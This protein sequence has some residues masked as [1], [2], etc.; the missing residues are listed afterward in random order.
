MLRDHAAIG[1]R[2]TIAL[3]AGDATIDWWS[4]DALDAPASLFSL[5]ESKRG[6]AV[7]IKPNEPRGPGE[8]FMHASGAPIVST[9]VHD[10][11]GSVKV[12][13]HLSKGTIVRVLTGRSGRPT[14][15]VQVTP[16]EAFGDPRK[17]KRWSHGVSFGRLVVRGPAVDQPITLG[18]GERAVFTITTSDEGSV[19][20]TAE[21]FVQPSIG[22]AMAEIERYAR[23]WSSELDNVDLEGPFA[24]AARK[25]VRALRL[26]TDRRTG[27]LRR[28]ATTSLPARTGNERNI[29]E[30]YAWL[31]DNASAVVTWERLGRPDLADATRLWLEE[32]AADEFPLAP[33]YR[34]DG[35][36]LPSEEELTL[37]GWQANGP[38]RTGNLVSEA[39]DL[40]AI[41]QASL[42]LDGRRAWPQLERIAAWLAAEGTRADCGRWDS[43]GPKY[44]HVESALAVR[45]ALRALIITAR[46]RDP[47]DLRLIEWEEAARR[48][49]CWLAEEGLFGI[50]ASAGWRRTGNAASSRVGSPGFG[51]DETTDG[52]LL[53]WLRTAPPELPDDQE[54]EANHRRVVTL[55]Q[56]LPQLTEW[57]FTHRHLPHVDDGLPPGQ[58]ADLW[59]SFTMVSALCSAQRWE[60]AH[61]RMD[62]LV[63]FLGPLHVG[64]THADPFS[65]D[66]R[67]NLLAAPC[68]LALIDAAQA[69]AN[70][71]R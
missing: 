61:N 22:E 60:D 43:R 34:S 68:H 52:S 31:R 66:L 51:A 15:T 40:G 18:L 12:T 56:T 70:G 45:A 25:S 64:A 44:R 23:W 16:G 38:V 30:R 69:L 39:F 17:V 8:Q 2:S 3:V 32:R 7:R 46:R 67:G 35:S 58:G 55:D 62:A 13:D 63:S 42:V 49:E 53:A 36:R 28:A 26:L 24:N 54:N 33:A 59:T 14:I 11:E 71:P 10:R 48:Q 20:H 1:D 47:L 5:L 29:D 50:G 9:V 57:P 27:A 21:Q 19:T 4:P 6:G 41:A 37:P 65:M